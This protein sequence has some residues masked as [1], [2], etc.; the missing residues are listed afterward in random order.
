MPQ[1]THANNLESLLRRRDFFEQ[2]KAQLSNT[3]D[4]ILLILP[5]AFLLI[6]I[7]ALSDSDDI[8]VTNQYLIIA[9][10]VLLALTVSLTVLS[11]VSSL[12]LFKRQVNTTEKQIQAELENKSLIL[13]EDD[14]AESIHSLRQFAAGAFIV[15]VILLGPLLLISTLTGQQ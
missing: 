9:G 14:S 7:M 1:S 5:S 4:K 3:Y 10:G 6:L 13:Q 15:A 8:T 2:Y 12:K 11:M